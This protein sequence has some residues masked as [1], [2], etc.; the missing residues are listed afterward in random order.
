MCIR[1]FYIDATVNKN[2]RLK[3]IKSFFI[4]VDK[5]KKN[6]KKIDKTVKYRM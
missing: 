1:S 4:R 2:L 6:S 3:Y 5:F